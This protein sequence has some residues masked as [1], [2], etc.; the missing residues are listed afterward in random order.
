MQFAE[1]PAAE[2]DTK[3]ARR[4]RLRFNRI[5]RKSNFCACFFH[6]LAA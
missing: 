1:G 3:P 5:M 6:T 4:V 2:Y